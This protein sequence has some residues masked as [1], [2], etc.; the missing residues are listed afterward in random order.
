MVIGGPL[1]Q[2]LLQ[3]VLKKTLKE[4][5]FKFAQPSTFLAKCGDYQEFDIQ[6]HKECSESLSLL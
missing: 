6:L 4:A 2:A 1:G 3:V 5:G